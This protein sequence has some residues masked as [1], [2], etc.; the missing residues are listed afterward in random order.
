MMNYEFINHMP[1]PKVRQLLAY[2]N[3]CLYR[4]KKH[5]WCVDMKD[6]WREGKTKAEKR[7]NELTN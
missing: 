6:T 7:L 1:E 4:V 5:K 3:D 2:L